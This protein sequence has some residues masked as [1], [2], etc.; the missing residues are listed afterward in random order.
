[1][2]LGFGLILGVEVFW[3]GIV[4]SNFDLGWFEGVW[5]EIVRENYLNFGENSV[6]KP[7]SGRSAVTLRSAL[8][9]CVRASPRYVSGIAG[10]IGR[11]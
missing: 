6:L 4:E 11:T 7:F 5:F 8:A 2:W 1:M 9:R 3:C 10:Y